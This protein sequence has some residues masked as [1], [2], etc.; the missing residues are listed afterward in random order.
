MIANDQPTIFPGNVQVVVS[1][2]A[3]GSVKYGV[4]ESD[5]KVASNLKALASKLGLSKEQ[6]AGIQIV[7]DDGQTYDVIVEAPA[8]S[9]DVTNK[10]TWVHCDALVTTQKGL[11]MLIPIADCNG[12]VV[13]DP[14]HEVLALAH[15]GW[16][17]AVANLPEKLI[18]YLATKHQSKPADLLVYISPSIRQDSY[19]HPKL[20]QLDDPAWKDFIA[21]SSK[22]YHLDVFGFVHKQL[23]DAGVLEDRI[24]ASSVDVAQS[25]DYF[26][27]FAAKQKDQQAGRY[28]VLCVLN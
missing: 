27:H 3:D 26:S 11:G 13:Y 15:V 28:A 9:Y 6:I 12:V 1:S 5:E 17:A 24:E 7:Y 22:G 10:A 21:E 19:Y 25:N 18:N 8:G 23:V 2:R 14:E 20:H 4:D 16:H